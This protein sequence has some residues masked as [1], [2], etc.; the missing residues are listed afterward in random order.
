MNPAPLKRG[1]LVRLLDKPIP[2]NHI[3]AEVE[4]ELAGAAGF[5]LKDHMRMFPWFERDKTWTSD[6]LDRI[7][8]TKDQFSKAVHGGERTT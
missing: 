5:K 1:D 3:P 2:T 4:V 7:D 8:A 6:K